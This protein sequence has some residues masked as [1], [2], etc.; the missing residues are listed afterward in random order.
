M[1]KLIIINTIQECIVPENKIRI[2]HPSK[3]VNPLS[4]N[5]PMGKKTRQKELR[6]ANKAVQKNYVN[7][8][9]ACGCYGKVT[10]NRIDLKSVCMTHAHSNIANIA[11]IV[12]YTIQGKLGAIDYHTEQ[13]SA[14]GYVIS[15]QGSN[16]LAVPLTMIKRSEK[17]NYKIKKASP[18]KRIAFLIKK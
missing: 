11:A 7:T 18:K 10:E 1:S 15:K 17:R 16:G 6:A 4:C 14:Y 9:L 3:S 12:D 5:L 2:K 8:R 13:G